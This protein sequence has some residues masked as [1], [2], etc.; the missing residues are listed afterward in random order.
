MGFLGGHVTRRLVA[1]G[2]DVTIFDI[3]I[4]SERDSIINDRRERLRPRLHLVE[5]DVGNAA[6]V[7]KLCDE[8][9]FDVVFHF[10]AFS[11]IEKSA[12]AP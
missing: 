3:D 8:N 2:A 1:L 9:T 5:G 6:A 12:N 4:C 7:D 11:V 10:A